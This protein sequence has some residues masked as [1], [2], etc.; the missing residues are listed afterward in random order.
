M[1]KRNIFDIV[2]WYINT[3]PLYNEIDPSEVYSLLKR[4]ISINEINLKNGKFDVFFDNYYVYTKPIIFSF[5]NTNYPEVFSKWINELTEVP[6]LGFAY[7]DFPGFTHIDLPNVKEVEK[8]AFARSSLEEI[9]LPN[10]ISIDEAAFFNAHELRH[11]VVPKKFEDTPFGFNN[12][13]GV[14]ITYV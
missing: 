6:Y 7:I 9:E 5:Y 2:R 3:C 1:A 14:D 4:E 12:S 10:A 11:I 8:Y 13:L